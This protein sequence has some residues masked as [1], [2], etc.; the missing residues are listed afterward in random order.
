MGEYIESNKTEEERETKLKVIRNML[1]NKEYIDK[2]QI[3][4]N[5]DRELYAN[6]DR[7]EKCWV[8]L[9][10]NPYESDDD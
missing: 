1:R 5:V 9:K 3:A 10:D 6:Y 7:Y 4:E 8:G 2:N